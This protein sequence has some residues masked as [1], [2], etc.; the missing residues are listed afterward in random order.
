[1][2]LCFC[3]WIRS[4]MNRRNP[5]SSLSVPCASSHSFPDMF[6]KSSISKELDDSSICPRDMQ[7]GER[8]CE[9][10]EESEVEGDEEA[11]GVQK[12]EEEEEEEAEAEEEEEEEEEEE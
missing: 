12:E 6:T 3:L 1:M 8:D 7:F 4:W 9:E 5:S 2:T 10:G 11:E